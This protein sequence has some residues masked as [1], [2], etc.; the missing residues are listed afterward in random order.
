MNKRHGIDM[1]ITLTDNVYNQFLILIWK[2]YIY[3][4]MVF[5]QKIVGK[6]C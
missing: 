5:Y 1:K 4:I 2:K 6:H 3:H